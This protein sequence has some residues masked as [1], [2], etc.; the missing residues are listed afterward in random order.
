MS[1]LNIDQKSV[2]DLFNHKKTNFLIP[3]YQRPYAWGENECQTLWDDLF[4]FSF[5]DDNCDKFDSDSDEYFL[6]PIVTFKN[7]KGQMEIIDGQQRLTTLMLLLR[8][9]YDKYGHMKDDKSIK[10]SKR[11]EQCIWK[12]DEF[13]DADQSNLK[14]DSEVATD[15]DKEEFLK[16]L[17]T[18]IVDKNEK[19]RYAINYR[20][21]Q[22][23]IAEFLND[24]PS[25]FSFLPTRIMQ[26]CILLP[27]E[28][29]TQDTAL[30]I[31]STLNDRGKPLS[32]AD[33]FKAQFYKYYS[34][35]GEKDAFIQK[36]ND[37]SKLCDDIFPSS[38]GSS[39]DEIFTRYMYYE[40]AILGIKSSTTEA[41]RR[42]YERD[43][44]RLLKNDETF[45]NL[46]DLANF[47]NDVDNQDEERFSLD[48]LK[49]LYVLNY[50]PNGMWTYFVSVYYM[51]NRDNEGFLDQEEFYQFLNKITG[52]IWAY[53]VTNP[54][55]NALRAPVY[56]EMINLVHGKPVRFEEYLFD[57]EH[58]NNAFNNFVFANQRPITRAMLTWWEFQDP[59]QPLLE[60]GN[61]MEIEH[62]YA[63][64]RQE[65]ERSLSNERNLESLGNKALL[66]KKINIRAADYKFNDKKRYYLGFTNNR[67]QFKEGTKNKELIDL[68]NA[69]D[70][71][72]ES[73]I[74]QRHAKI[75]SNFIGF[76]NSNELLKQE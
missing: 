17:K 45:E 10:T 37:L 16:I 2:F 50:A 40:R 24:Y 52:F 19:S 1:K 7:E 26:N 62:I 29:E 25:W 8:A 15:D 56:A 41:L 27:I 32:D 13:G 65:I 73:D 20:F 75:I 43:G 5:P 46:I 28:A 60:L 70:D 4:L 64:K 61:K 63:K 23:K 38:S 66:E 44:Y 42:F 6:G 39:L 35:K 22:E 71:F 58:V 55:V 69:S 11:I 51:A 47:W 57:A 36:W 31:F 49:M 34:D 33:I 53:A 76:L 9:F 21:F 72:T 59:E 74:M 12:T 30:R 48:V 54:G 18:G 68:A 14:I 3:D 67:N